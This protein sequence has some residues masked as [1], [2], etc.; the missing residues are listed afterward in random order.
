VFRRTKEEYET[1]QRQY[2]KKPIYR[3]VEI[4]VLPIQEANKLIV[5]DKQYELIGNDPVKVVNGPF[6]AIV[7]KKQREQ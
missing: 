1:R 6:F 3:I 7:G 4:L 2:F 5:V